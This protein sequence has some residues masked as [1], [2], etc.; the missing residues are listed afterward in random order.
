MPLDINLL[1]DPATA[2]IV[3]ESERKRFNPDTTLVDRQE[4][5]R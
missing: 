4:Q 1:R 5:L 3:R 2:E